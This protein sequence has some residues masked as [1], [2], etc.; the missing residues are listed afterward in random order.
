MTTVGRVEQAQAPLY[1]AISSDLVTWTP[2]PAIELSSQRAVRRHNLGVVLRQVVER[3]P[4]SRATIALDTGLNK[5]T[6]SS[7]VSE[8]MHLGLLVERG[9][10]ARAT[11]GR[12]GL[13]VDVAREGAVA[14]GLEINVDYLGVQA[15]DLAG[16]SRYKAIEAADN[17]RRGVD[18][19]LDRLADLA[20]DALRE[21]RAQGLR[22]IGATVA[23][24][25]L[26]DVNRGAL[27]AAPN[28]HWTDVPVVELLRERMDAD[29]LPLG[30][31]N[32]ANLAALA[33]LWEGAAVGLSDFMYASG[34]VG[35]GGGIVLGGEL[36][37]G[38]RGFGGEFGHM[39]VEADG[40]DCACGSRG[41]LETRGGLEPLLAAAGLD[42][43]QITTTGSGKP[44]AELVKRAGAGEETA[45]AAL[46]DCG[47]W[48]GI[49][50]GSVVNL[51][52]PQT[53]VLG[54]Y[55]AP[56]SEWLKPPIE[57]ELAARVLGGATAVPPVLPSIL[58]PEAAVRG[59]AA[60]QLRRVLA[61]PTLVDA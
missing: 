28:L 56:I 36:F 10:E 44:V 46:A 41:C 20:N 29:P 27:L 38:Y 19:V 2:K 58:G 4:R 11:A 30:A 18:V 42:G 12:P 33:E 1:P 40:L 8:L 61:D 55:F 59:A 50:L 31:D 16:G 51:L 17:R 39:T 5:T 43:E 34:Q 32:E 13:V 24:P 45:L 54:G 22:P 15:T 47:R 21:V 48:L 3:G 53:I 26:V 23:L 49:A 37:R 60:T 35:V 57:R 9:A 7:L 6:V 14:L 25:G 52:S